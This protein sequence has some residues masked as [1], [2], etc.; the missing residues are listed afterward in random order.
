MVGTEETLEH[1]DAKSEVSKETMRKKLG[2]S[3]LDQ[4]RANRSKSKQK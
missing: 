1:D 2:N 3:Y 4:M